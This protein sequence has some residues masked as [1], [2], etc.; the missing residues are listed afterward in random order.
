M[1]ETLIY[2]VLLKVIMLTIIDGPLRYMHAAGYLS[3]RLTDTQRT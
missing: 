3:M 2:W 1:T